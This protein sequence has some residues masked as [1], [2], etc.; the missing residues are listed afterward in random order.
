MDIGGVNGTAQFVHIA[1]DAS[2]VSTSD[3]DYS[4]GAR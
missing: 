1:G 2:D 3:V 4:S